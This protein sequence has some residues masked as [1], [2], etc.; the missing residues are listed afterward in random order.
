MG[1]FKLTLDGSRI[2]AAR[3]AFGGMAATPKR[4]HTTEAALRGID[5]RQPETWDAAIARLDADFSPITDQRAGADYRRT[6]ARA[7]LGKALTEIAGT[8]TSRTR[9]VGFREDAHAAA[10]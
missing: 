10:S 8:P 9:V 7:L 1:A 4:A 2:E 6:V 5:L 3:I